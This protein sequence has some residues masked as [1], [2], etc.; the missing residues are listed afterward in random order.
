MKLEEA[1]RIT[2]PITEIVPFLTPREDDD[3]MGV[4]KVQPV[5]DSLTEAYH[6]NDPEDDDDEQNFDYMVHY[7]NRLV[8]QTIMH[9]VNKL[10]VVV[11]EFRNFI[12][13]L[14]EEYDDLHTKNLIERAEKVLDDAEEVEV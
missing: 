13:A 10:P 3:P 8:A 4:Y 2:G 14:P 5:F 1:M 11:Q 12:N 9:C 7:P 6:N